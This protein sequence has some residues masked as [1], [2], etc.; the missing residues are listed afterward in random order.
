M[1]EII[2]LS[3][4]VHGDMVVFPRVARPV[5]A[6]LE[7]WEEFAER[8]GAA[9][10]GTTWLTASCVIVQGDHVGT[11]IDSLRHLRDDARLARKAFPLSIVMVMA[12][13]WISGTN[14]SVMASL[15]MI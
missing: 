12:C 9:Q 14:P 13:C 3:M 5:I 7:N 15:W 6:M 1:T 10:Y 4:P 8:I 11:H 2:D